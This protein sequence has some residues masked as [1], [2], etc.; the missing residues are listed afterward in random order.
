MTDSREE[1]LAA[2]LRPSESKTRTL[3]LSGAVLTVFGIAL[4]AAGDGSTARW[5]AIGGLLC[6]LIGLHRFGRLGPDEGNGRRK[7]EAPNV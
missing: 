2:A 3:I 4:S 1:P 6:L 7:N 5:L